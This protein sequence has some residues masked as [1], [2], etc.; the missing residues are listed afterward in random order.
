M[1]ACQSILGR[2]P[3]NIF[4]EWGREKEMDLCLKGGMVGKAG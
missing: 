2:A 1:G 3:K 4:V